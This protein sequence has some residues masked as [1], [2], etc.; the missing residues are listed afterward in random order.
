VAKGGPVLELAV[1]D[2]IK[3]VVKVPERYLP[4]LAVGGR[5]CA[6]ADALPGREFCG[7][8]QAVIPSGDDKSRTF[9]VQVRIANPQGEIKPGMLMRVALAAGQKHMALL[10]PKDALVMS[11]DSLSI[12]AVEEGKAASVPVKVVAAHG[13]L[14]EVTG[15]LKPGQSIVTAGNERLFPGQPVR[16]QPAGG[17]AK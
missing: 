3:V 8:I 16:V 9:P 17:L 7:Q 6:T 1:L 12:F 10:I 14:L 4:A 2:P 11:G 15:E 5:S 13:G